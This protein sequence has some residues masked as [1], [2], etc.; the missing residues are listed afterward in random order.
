M[1]PEILGD[2]LAG[3]T[4]HL[5]GWSHGH[6]R[7]NR[8]SSEYGTVGRISCE[9]MEDPPLVALAFLNVRLVEI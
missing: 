7:L 3:A 8:L 6:T 2:P 4:D 1:G 9:S 5:K